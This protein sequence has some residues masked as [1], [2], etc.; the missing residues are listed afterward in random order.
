VHWSILAAATVA[1]V[2]GWRIPPVFE[3]FEVFDAR[4][5]TGR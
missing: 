1:N 4:S 3:A 5:F 2:I